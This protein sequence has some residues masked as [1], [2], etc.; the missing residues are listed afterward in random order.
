MSLAITLAA[1][2][3]AIRAYYGAADFGGDRQLAKRFHP[4]QKLR[5]RSP[6]GEFDTRAVY[7]SMGMRDGEHS[8]EAPPGVRRILVLGDSFAEAKQV[9]IDAGFPAL[10]EGAL[11]ASRPTEVINAG[12]SGFGA[13]EEYLTFKHFGVERRPHSVVQA[14]FVNDIWDD[15]EVSPHTQW[16]PDG[17]PLRMRGQPSEL[18]RFVKSRLR[19][20]RWRDKETA[21]HMAKLLRGAT[22]DE[23]LTEEN[24]M[25]TLR[26]IEGS[27]ELARSIGA[28]YLLVLIPLREQ[29]SS[30]RR[31]DAGDAMQRRL[32]AFGRARG[33]EVLDL[34]PILA[35][36]EAPLYFEQDGHWNAEGHRVAAGA[37]A[38]RLR[39]DRAFGT[40]RR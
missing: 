5:Y 7:N 6:H 2:E 23:F 26:V 3:L 21:R 9:A 19:M 30:R 16:G 39:S 12:R 8:R 13:I 10:L 11:S 36:R 15:L 37:I 31:G 29:V 4:H 28:S 38:E 20:A 34:L 35:A 24:W 40:E 18:L 32:H 14:F 1:A 25:R 17:L 27:R 22:R 33:I